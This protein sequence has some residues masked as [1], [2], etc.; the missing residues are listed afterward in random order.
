MN[1]FREELTMKLYIDPGHGGSDPG[2]VGNGLKEKDITLDIAKR[3]R[4]ILL[5]KY[6][7]IDIRLSRTRDQTKGLWQRTNEANSWGANY[8]VSIHCNAFNGQANGYEDF[9]YSGLSNTSKTAQYQNILHDEI[10]KRI[11]LKNRGK[12]KAGFHVLRETK[13]P[14]FLSENGF[15]D[16]KQNAACMHQVGWREKVAEGHAIGIAKAFNLKPK[17]RVTSPMKYQVIAGSFRDP[18]NA[19][20]RAAYLQSKGIATAVTRINISKAPIYRVQAGSFKDKAA[21]E[22]QV[23]RI[24]Q[25]GIDAFLLKS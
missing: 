20:I 15:I 2:A 21:A 6:K 4:T 14:A 7:G 3:L 11:G 10:T 8:F 9:I 23:K 16:H 24:E 1:T 25:I 13:M 5:S 22:R 19:E 17:Q 12:K 18:M